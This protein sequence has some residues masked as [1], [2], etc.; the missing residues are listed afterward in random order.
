[1]EKNSKMTTDKNQIEAAMRYVLGHNSYITLEEADFRRLAPGPDC[2]IHVVGDDAREAIDCL[3]AECGAVT[4]PVRR[5]VTFVKSETL[6]MNELE[7]VVGC[8]P[9]VK[10]YKGGLCFGK[11]KGGTVEVMLFLKTI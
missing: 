5:L 10:G 6:T 2:L 11:P 1:M 3:E 8:F 9:E 7:D 4:A